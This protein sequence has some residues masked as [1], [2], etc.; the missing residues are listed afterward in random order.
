MYHF[1]VAKIVS[2][3]DQLMDSTKVF[4]LFSFNFSSLSLKQYEHSFFSNEK[5]RSHLRL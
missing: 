4:L 2:L 1:Y 3:G 5:S